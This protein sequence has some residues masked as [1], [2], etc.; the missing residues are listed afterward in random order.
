VPLGGLLAPGWFLHTQAV[1][2][3]AGLPGGVGQTNAVRVQW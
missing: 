1:F 2:S 3:D